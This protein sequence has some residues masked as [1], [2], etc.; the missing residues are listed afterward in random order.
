MTSTEEWPSSSY[1]TFNDSTLTFDKSVF[2]FFD[3][4][5]RFLSCILDFQDFA[6]F[7]EHFQYMSYRLKFLNLKLTHLKASNPP[8]MNDDISNLDFGPLHFEIGSLD[9]FSDRTNS[10]NGVRMH[11]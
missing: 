11:N 9:Y 2:F 4:N 7:E 8:Q 10:N 5:P 3:K 1:R 6:N